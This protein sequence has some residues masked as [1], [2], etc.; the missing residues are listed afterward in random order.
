MTY[1]KK[2]K[3]LQT[4]GKRGTKEQWI[5]ASKRN[6]DSNQQH[7]GATSMIWNLFQ[8]IQLSTNRFN[9]FTLMRYEPTAHFATTTQ[10][11]NGSTRLTTLRFTLTTTP[12]DVK[13]CLLYAIHLSQRY[14]S[15]RP[16]ST[17]CTH[18]TLGAMWRLAFSSLCFICLLC[19]A[20][21][22]PSA[23]WYATLSFHSST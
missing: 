8:F 11:F 18:A 14:A 3:Y 15:T 6:T 17:L 13:A 2:Y 20:L 16:S 10:S 4:I 21:F 23:N 1:I 9:L 19:F 5:S 12:S 7:S 22:K